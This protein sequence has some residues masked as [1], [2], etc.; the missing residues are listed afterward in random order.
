MYNQE[1]SIKV[2]EKVPLVVFYGTADHIVD[3]EK[4]VK[5]LND[6][7]SKLFPALELVHAERI[8]GY[9]HMDTIW[10]H[11]N[12]ITTYPIILDSLCNKAKWD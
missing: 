4:L 8:E 10:A 9:E 12:H 2:Q 5:T 3:G 6:K 11:D 1:S 7:S